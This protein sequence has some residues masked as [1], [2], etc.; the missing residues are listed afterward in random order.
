[1]AAEVAPWSKAGGLGDVIGA[2]PV[3]LAARGLPV[4]SVAPFYEAYPDTFDTGIV[5]PVVH[6]ALNPPEGGAEGVD[7]SVARLHAVMQDGVLRVFVE[8]P[9][10]SGARP[11][12]HTHFRNVTALHTAA[13]ETAMQ[14]RSE[15]WSNTPHELLR[16][17]FLA[18][19]FRCANAG[20]G[21]CIYSS[22]TAGGER[23][24]AVAMHVF[25]QGSTVACF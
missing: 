6:P 18:N 13:S 20:V 5:L 1:M 8:H 2:L 22:Y 15:L 7:A 17:C 14:C 9:L 11:L 24:V 3:A 25:C 10:F 12:S 16:C 21:S 19:Y 23:D 4:L